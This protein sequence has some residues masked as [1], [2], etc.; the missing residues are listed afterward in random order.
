VADSQQPTSTHN[1]LDYSRTEEV[2]IEQLHDAG[3]KSDYWAPTFFGLGN[4]L[5]S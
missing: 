5:R 1:R 4:A 2:M 3:V